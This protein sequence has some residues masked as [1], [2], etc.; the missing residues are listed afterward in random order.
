MFNSAVQEEKA[1]WV[2]KKPPPESRK[3]R[4]HGN[5][6]DGKTVRKSR[7][8]QSMRKKLLKGYSQVSFYK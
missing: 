7:Q 5:S 1:C 3:S 4:E 6:E 2:W 8:G